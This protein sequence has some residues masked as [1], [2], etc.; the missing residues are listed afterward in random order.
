MSN[1]T[2]LT[3]SDPIHSTV[4]QPT[5][6]TASDRVKATGGQVVEFVFGSGRYMV[7]PHPERGSAL[8]LNLQGQSLVIPVAMI[9][10][11]CGRLGDITCD[12]VS[13]VLC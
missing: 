6:S 11:A 5:S 12:I 10:P 8:A 2:D 4:S 7:S 1:S 3:A 9:A 13:G